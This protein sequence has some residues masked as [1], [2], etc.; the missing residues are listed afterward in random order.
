MIPFLIAILILKIPMYVILNSAYKQM[1][2]RANIRR[3][4]TTALIF[5]LFQ[6]LT[7]IAAILYQITSPYAHY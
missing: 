3:T 7:S 4:I 1:W 6:D 5:S 2:S